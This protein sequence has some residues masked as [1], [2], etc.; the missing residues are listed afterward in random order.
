[1]FTRLG[2]AV[3]RHPLLVIGVWILLALAVGRVAPPWDEVTHE[4][5]EDFLP[6]EMTSVRGA[7]LLDAAFPDLKFKSQVA[8]VAER[9]DGPLSIEDLRLID[10]LAE[11]FESDELAALPIAGVWTRRHD[12]VG[13]MLTS[14]VTEQGQ[15]ELIVLLLSNEFM[16][17]RNIDVLETINRVLDETRASENIPP[18]LRLG[19]SG[20]AAIGGDMLASAKESIDNTEIATIL[21]V[22]GILLVV[23]RA[24][25]LIF[26]PLVTI[27]VSVAVSMDLVALLSAY[28]EQVDF[29]GYKTFKT[30][31]IFIIVLLFGAGT[32]YCLFL[33]ARYREELRR[34]TPVPAAVS[35]ALGGV[36][37][38][39]AASAL[40]TIVGLAMMYFADFGKFRYAGPTIAMCLTV[41]LLACLTLAPALLRFTGR[42]VFWPWGVGPPESDDA[43]TDRTWKSHGFEAVSNRFWERASRA[44]MACPGLILVGGFALLLY[45]AWHGLSVPTSYNLLNELQ[46]DRP[47]VVGTN[48][49]RRHFAAGD[50]GPLTVV[51]YHTAGQFNTPEGEQNIARLTKSLYDVDGVRMVRSYAEPLGDP[52]G[53][54]NPF[55]RRGQKKIVAKHHPLT[56]AIYLSND[57]EYA[58][59]VTRFDLVFDADPFSQESEDVLAAVDALLAEVSHDPSSPW[60]GADFDLVG[61]TAATRDLQ[62]VTESD[63]VRI[64]QLVVIAVFAVLLVILRRPLICGYLILSVVFSYLVTIGATEMFFAWVYGPTFEGLDWKVPIFLF[65]ILVAVGEDY[66]IYL[67]TRVFQEQRRHGSQEG[68]RRAIVR[69]GGII[70][71]C[72]LIMAGTFLSMIFGSL[73]GMLE[74][75][76]ALAL[77]VM[78]D[79]F[80]VRPVLVPAFLA[81]LAR[82]EPLEQMAAAEGGE[83][84][85]EPPEASPLAPHRPTATSVRS[86]RVERAGRA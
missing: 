9:P 29:I 23:Y 65:V 43:D 60:H 63:Q 33:I 49:L 78:L 85:R 86:D 40:T 84:V 46:A 82:R 25:I 12:V 30:T 11:R 75:G 5:N 10:A 3:A 36:G 53:Y 26:V 47:S 24:P 72:G 21:L 58:G 44:I 7:R 22:V 66:N 59:R 76:F 14:R 35:A 67:V 41:A 70:T 83:A 28:S 55:S 80:V 1:M 15:A 77:G 57:P 13:P 34:G 73:R 68:L 61:T 50:I 19:V 71:S 2:S 48:M 69:T 62:R 31:K 38:A 74:L 79:T 64:Q 37:D 54:V 52:P 42:I 32:D 17:I 8:L 27:F 18:G 51:A 16:D 4:G 6:R 45:P 56:R 81:L 39:L 20:S